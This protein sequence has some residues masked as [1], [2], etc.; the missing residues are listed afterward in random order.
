MRLLT[1]LAGYVRFKILSH[2]SFL[3][4]ICWFTFLKRVEMEVVNLHRWWEQKEQKLIGS[5]NMMSFPVPLVRTVCTRQFGTCFPRG[6]IFVCHAKEPR[7]WQWRPWRWCLLNDL[8]QECEKCLIENG[9]SSSSSVH[10]I[11][12]QIRKPTSYKPPSIDSPSHALFH[13]SHPNG[14]NFQTVG[15]SRIS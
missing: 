13:P 15:I 10:P 1:F 3:D 9:V 5:R 12:N 11:T 14:K 6:W 8:D 4:G 7:T 2:N